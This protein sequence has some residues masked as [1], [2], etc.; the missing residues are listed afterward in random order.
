MGSSVAYLPGGANHANATAESTVYTPKKSI[1]EGGRG[2]PGGVVSRTPLAPWHFKSLHGKN[3]RK[4]ES[5]RTDTPNMGPCASR[6]LVWSPPACW[7][8]GWALPPS[9]GT[10]PLSPS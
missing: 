2:E 4:N 7:W 9:C 10:T 5:Q 3:K 8:W 1:G 6:A